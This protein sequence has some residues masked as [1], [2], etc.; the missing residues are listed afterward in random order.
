MG[1][2]EEELKADQLAR[3]EA[4]AARDSARL[5]RA[6]EAAETCIHCHRR[7]PRFEATDLINPICSTCLD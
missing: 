7:F 6:L 1:F 4:E 5:T 3:A 2:S